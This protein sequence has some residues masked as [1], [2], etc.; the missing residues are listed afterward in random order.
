LP[1]GLSVRKLGTVSIRRNEIVADLFSRMHMVERTGMGTRKMRTAMLA[2]DLQEP[3]FETAAPEDFFRA[4]FRRSP[5]FAL[6][7]T[8]P[9]T[10]ETGKKTRMK[11]GKKTRMKA[12]AEILD[13]I[14]ANSDRTA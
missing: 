6:K 8:A 3:V 13:L 7:E 1:K 10:E 12:R 11:T 14:R 2:A 9:G 4:I 5:E